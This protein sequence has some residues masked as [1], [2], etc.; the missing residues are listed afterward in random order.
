MTRAGVAD[1]LAFVLWFGGAG[2]LWAGW[3]WHP[4]H[5]FL[6]IVWGLILY[7]VAFF[8]LFAWLPLRQFSRRL[9]KLDSHG[10]WQ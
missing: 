8:Y 5:P 7:V 9:L 3:E 6:D 10:M 4:S 1:C 2:L